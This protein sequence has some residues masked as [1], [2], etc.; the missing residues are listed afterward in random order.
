[1]RAETEAESASS[2]TAQLLRTDSTG[3]G[4]APA[5]EAQQWGLHGNQGPQ[6]NPVGELSAYREGPR[7][8]RCRILQVPSVKPASPSPWH[9]CLLGRLDWVNARE[10]ILC[11]DMWDKCQLLLLSLSATASYLAVKGSFE[12][13]LLTRGERGGEDVSHRDGR[14]QCRAACEAAL[15]ENLTMKY[16]CAPLPGSLEHSGFRGLQV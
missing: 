1:M 5:A 8:R 4:P 13:P 14:I 3:H 11:R 15:L 10:G 6:G 2:L 16:S 9:L 12:R 7:R